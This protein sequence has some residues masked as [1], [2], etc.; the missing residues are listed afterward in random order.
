MS[1]AG[2]VQCKC[3]QC[4]SFFR[5]PVA[6]KSTYI[7]FFCFLAFFCDGCRKMFVSEGSCVGALYLLLV[8]IFLT[9]SHTAVLTLM[10][11]LLRFSCVEGP[12]AL[13]VTFS[14]F[15]VVILPFSSCVLGMCRSVF[16]FANGCSINKD[17]VSVEVE[18]LSVSLFL[19]L[20]GPVFNNNLDVVCCLVA[21]VSVPRLTNTRS[22]LFCLLVRHNLLNVLKCL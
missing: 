2:S 13:L 12:G 18:R 5:F 3:K 11:K 4:G 8:N 19:F 7:M 21:S 1:R 16:S 14:V 17:S 9:G 20:R 22:R 15:L 6:F 10:F